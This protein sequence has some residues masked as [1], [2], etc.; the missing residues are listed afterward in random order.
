MMTAGTLELVLNR[1]QPNTVTVGFVGYDF[2]GATF[3]VQLRPYRDAPDPALLTLSNASS[4]SE[5]VSVTVTTMDGIPTS[6]VEMRFAEATVEGLPFTSPVG[7]DYS[8]VWDLVI[9]PSGGT[10]A[11][12]VE[13]PAIIHGGST[14]V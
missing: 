12:W 9:T 10:K 1:W 7:T 2:T 5:G 13:G 4:P 6:V 14:Q 3:N 11:R 8:C